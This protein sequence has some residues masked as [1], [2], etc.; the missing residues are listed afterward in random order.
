[1]TRESEQEEFSWPDTR[2]LPRSFFNA[3]LCSDL[4][5]LS[6]DVAFLGV[7]FD[8]GTLN[9]PGARFGPD[10][11]RDVPYVY[12]YSNPWED[13]EAQGYFDLDAGGGVELLK[14]VTFAD[15]GNVTILPS[16]VERN[17]DKLTRA[18]RAIVDRSAFPVL[19]GGDHSITYPAVRGLERFGPLDIVHFDAHQDFTHH[20]QGVELFHGSPIRRV[21]EL[22]FVRHVTSL[23]IRH[24]RKQVYAEALGRGV[25]TITTSQLKE[26]GPDKAISQIPEAQYIY[27]T[28]D[29]D[30]L[31]PTSAPGTGTPV[32][33]G[34]S[35]FDLRDI[36]VQV[37]RR[38]RIVGMD[39]VEVA[40]PYDV[41]QV[42][43]MTAARLIIDLL[44][45]LFPSRG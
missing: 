42:T 33:G 3:P 30:V 6:A 29:I 35:Y 13:R 44:G 8:Q 21:S 40:P 32:I 1:M 38:G 41:S 23:G 25:K 26:M 39:V 37:P 34:L 2:A 9:R 28:L 36:L 31:D 15:C 7:P 5:D 24:A 17:F 27:V 11:V 16:D 22:P 45:V 43:A 12:P 4:G 14:G 19:V 10:G 20:L 18:V